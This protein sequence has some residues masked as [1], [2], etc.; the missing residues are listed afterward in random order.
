MSHTAAFS[1]ETVNRLLFPDS[2]NK[3]AVGEVQNF[4]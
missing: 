4:F 3:Y 1:L 2:H